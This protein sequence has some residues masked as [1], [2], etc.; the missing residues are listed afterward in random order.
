MKKKIFICCYRNEIDTLF[1]WNIVHSTSPFNKGND[2]SVD[3]EYLPVW[4]VETEFTEV[5][6]GVGRAEKIDVALFP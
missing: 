1:G 3:K 6:Y 4:H 2:V 5:K